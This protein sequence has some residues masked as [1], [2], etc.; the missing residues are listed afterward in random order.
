VADVVHA[1][2]VLKDS[3]LKVGYHMMPGLWSDEKKDVEMFRRLFAE[4][5]FRP[6]M[7]KIYPCLVLEG[8]ALWAQWKRGEFEPYDSEKAA[9]VI[10]EASRFI[11]PYCR[12][13]R[14]QR[15]IPSQLIAAGVKHGN[16]RQLVEE[17]M[18]EKGIR[19]RC[20][21]AVRQASLNSGALITRQ[22][23]AGRHS[24]LSR[25]KTGMRWLAL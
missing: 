12:V 25:R 24:S 9:E 20:C 1:T 3:A 19:C 23:G 6:D 7:L 22:A 8:T 18:K 2:Q 11:P 5:S 10:A 4:E 17:R 15:D 13:M 21:W 14:M 16:L